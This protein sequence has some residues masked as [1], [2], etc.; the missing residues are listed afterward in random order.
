MKVVILS[1][2]KEKHVREGSL[3]VK[4]GIS[5]DYERRKVSKSAGWMPWLS[6]AKKDVISCE[7]LWGGANNL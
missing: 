1:Y 5:G 4:A 7:K 6:E 2:A 3:G